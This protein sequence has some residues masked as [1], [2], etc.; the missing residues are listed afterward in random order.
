MN[1]LKVSVLL[2]VAHPYHG[3][4]YAWVVDVYTDEKIAQDVCDRLNKIDRENW[5]KWKEFNSNGIK[6]ETVKP[7]AWYSEKV[8]QQM[9]DIAQNAIP[10]YTN[11]CDSDDEDE[12]NNIPSIDEEYE[13]NHTDYLD[14]EEN[15]FNRDCH[16]DYNIRY[17]VETK[18][19][20]N[21]F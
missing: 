12:L 21:F 5:I 19:V 9:R 11:S 7:F 2:G 18:V 17:K 6:F 10:S 14:E 16:Y 20:S 1:N 3:N 4:S 15:G 13:F 8:L